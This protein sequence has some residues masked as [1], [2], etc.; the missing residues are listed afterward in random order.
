MGVKLQDLITREIIGFADLSGLLSQI[1]RETQTNSGFPR[2]IIV[3]I[4]LEK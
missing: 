1:T 2:L 4:T 3:A